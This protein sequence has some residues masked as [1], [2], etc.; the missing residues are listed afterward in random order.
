MC[1]R[2]Q[3]ILGK[4]SRT[5]GEPPSGRDWDWVGRNYY[6][7]FCMLLL[8]LTIEHVQ[9][10]KKTLI[11]LTQKEGDDPLS[12]NDNIDLMFERITERRPLFGCAEP[13]E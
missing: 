3:Q 1:E 10:R 5:W 9:V 13:K 12:A 4:L 8:C 2:L 7:P 11:L 6:V